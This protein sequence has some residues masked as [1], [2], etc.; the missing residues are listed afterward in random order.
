M[1]CNKKNEEKIIPAD[2]LSKNCDQ[3]LQSSSLNL[4]LYCIRIITLIIHTHVFRQ[5]HFY[6]INSISEI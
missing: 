3:I 6:E 1:N 4:Y 2:Y 5:I